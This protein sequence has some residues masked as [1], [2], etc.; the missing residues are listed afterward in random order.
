MASRQ[1]NQDPVHKAAAKLL[2]CLDAI[3]PAF[4]L[5]P[6]KILEIAELKSN[7]REALGLAGGAK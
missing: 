2:D 7:L 6:G 3:N 1:C 5:A 4:P